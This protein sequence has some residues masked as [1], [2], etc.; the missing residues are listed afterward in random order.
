MTPPP[1]TPAQPP[2]A[3]HPAVPFEQCQL[4]T[5]G[6]IP[7]AFITWAWVND[8]VDMRLRAG[9]A[10]IAP[11]EWKGGEHAWLIDIVTPFEAAEP[12]VKACCDKFMAGEKVSRLVAGSESTRVEEVPSAAR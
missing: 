7:F 3:A 2:F 8:E 11:H 5:K 4:L 10:K 1:A 9:V 12:Y 6:E